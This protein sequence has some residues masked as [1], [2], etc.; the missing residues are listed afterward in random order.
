MAAK[1][2][3]EDIICSDRCE[4]CPSPYMKQFPHGRVWIVGGNRYKVGMGTTATEAK[5]EAAKKAADKIFSGPGV[6]TC[7]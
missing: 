1:K 2:G 3:S 4:E 5:K 6:Y 7:C